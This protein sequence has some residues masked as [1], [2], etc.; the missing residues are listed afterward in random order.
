[1]TVPSGPVRARE[2]SATV[3]ACEI[4]KTW[5]STAWNS[6]SFMV[7]LCG[8]PSSGVITGYMDPKNAG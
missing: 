2:S 1:M 7:R 8:I 3:L 6:S 5:A 4:W